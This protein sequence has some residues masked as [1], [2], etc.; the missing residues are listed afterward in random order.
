MGVQRFKINFPTIFVPQVIFIDYLE[1]YQLSMKYN[2]IWNHE[3]W[4]FS[5]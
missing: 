1:F 2:I 5:M 4:E 3:K